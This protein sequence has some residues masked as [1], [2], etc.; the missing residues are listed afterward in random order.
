MAW[1]VPHLSHFRGALYGRH[2][3]LHG[4]DG[5]RT[6]AQGHVLCSARTQPGEPA[7]VGAS[8]SCAG[9]YLCSYMIVM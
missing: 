5:A 1:R 9:G 3:L 7:T 8:Y 2:D 4:G 6:L